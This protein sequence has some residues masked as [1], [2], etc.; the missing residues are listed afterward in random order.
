M[1]KILTIIIAT[2]LTVATVKAEIY[3]PEC[4]EDLREFMRQGTN[5]EKL[6]LTVADTL[7]WYENEDWVGKLTHYTYGPP[8]PD[9]TDTNGI[10]W[11]ETV[12]NKRIE[13]IRLQANQIEGNVKFHTPDL[14]ELQ[15]SNNYDLIKLDVSENIK[16]KYLVCWANSLSE[17]DVSKNIEL[18]YLACFRNELTELD[19][20]NNTR[21]S[22]LN[23][24]NNHLTELDVSKNTELIRLDCS[25]NRLTKLNVSNNETLMDLRCDQNKLRFSTLPIIEYDIMRTYRYVS[26]ATIDGGTKAYTDTVDLSSEYE[27]NENITTYEW[28]DLTAGTVEQ[29]TNENG[30]FTFTEEHAGKKLYCIMRNAQFPGLVLVYDVEIKTVNIKETT[31]TNFTVS[32]NPAQTQ[33]TIHHSKE[34]GK[35]GLYDLSGRLIRSYTVSD[36]NTVLDISGLDIG[37]YFITVDGKTV[38]FIKE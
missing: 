20:S 7:T 35:I 10:I 24:S 15:I 12:F 38:K 28:F 17:L 22:S 19:L 27:I 9:I 8:V 34:I 5:Y 26:Q 29:P 6:G 3:H 31:E 13:K 30:V 23:C 18:E 33:L 37:V 32:P 1:Q 14:T 16:L 21:L 25:H 2:V 4:K 36:T 11:T